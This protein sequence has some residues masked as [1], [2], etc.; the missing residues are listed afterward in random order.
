MSP[1]PDD[2]A[3]EATCNPC[4]LHFISVLKLSPTLSSVC[5]WVQ[6]C[7]NKYCRSVI[8]HRLPGGNLMYILKVVDANVS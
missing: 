2:R 1:G 5:A 7:E 3:Y 6:E 4:A 8:G